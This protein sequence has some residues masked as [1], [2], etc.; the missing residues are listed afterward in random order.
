MSYYDTEEV[1]RAVKAFWRWS[2]RTGA[3][4]IQPNRH[5][6]VTTDVKGRTVVEIR[7]GDD[8]L[9]TYEVPVAGR[10]RRLS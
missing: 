2:E 4:W 3:F 5:D 10:A 7:S 8:L 9:A 6:T 1:D